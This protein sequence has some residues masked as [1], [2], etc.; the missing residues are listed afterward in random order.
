MI[1]NSK[2]D[3]RLAAS[4]IAKARHAATSGRAV[5]ST[6]EQIVT[7]LLNGR[8]DWLPSRYEHPLKA[9][10]QVYAEDPVWFHTMIAVSERYET[11]KSVE[12]FEDRLS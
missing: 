3:P 8:S 1:D 11:L 4:F 5:G 7:A 10:R 6:S 2:F 9:I 12:M